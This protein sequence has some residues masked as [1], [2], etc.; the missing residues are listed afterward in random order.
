M[1]LDPGQLVNTALN[2]R[3]VA[4]KHEQR[5][6]PALIEKDTLE[7]DDAIRDAHFNLALAAPSAPADLVENVLADGGIIRRTRLSSS[8]RPAHGMHDIG[9][10]HD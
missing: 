3:H 8:Q 7:L 9:Y 2:A 1:P 5:S 4:R 6:V 10:R